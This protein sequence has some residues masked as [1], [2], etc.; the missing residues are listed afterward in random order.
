MD[1]ARETLAKYRETLA[2]DRRVLFDRYRLVV[3]V[4]DVAL[5]L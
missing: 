4:I 5:V 3:S 1:L 2:D